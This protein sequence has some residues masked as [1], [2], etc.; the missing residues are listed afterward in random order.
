MPTSPG[1]W[2]DG[3]PVR[4]PDAKRG[5]WIVTPWFDVTEGV[6]RC[7][8]VDVRSFDGEP[9]NP[10]D[11]PRVP[12]GGQV[13]DLTATELRSLPLAKLAAAAAAKMPD[14]YR[15][16]LAGEIPDGEYDAARLKENLAAYEQSS[17]RYGAKHLG[18]VA[19]VYRAALPSGRPTSAVAEHFNISR[20]AAA[21]QVARCR[22]VGLLGKT[23]KGRP[24]GGEPIPEVRR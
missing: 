18:E 7:V 12:R 10:D 6:V 15:Q 16:A 11:P 20:S 23:A 21:K 17:R 19:K 13:S 2:I 9:G 24:G 4:W 8:G 14:L 1:L 3:A 5:P 22:E